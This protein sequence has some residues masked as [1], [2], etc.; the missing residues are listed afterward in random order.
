MSLVFGLLALASAL[1]VSQQMIGRSSFE[2]GMIKEFKGVIRMEPYPHLLV[3]RPGTSPRQFSSYYL[4]KRYKFG[5]NPA[6]IRRFDGRDVSLKGTLIYRENRTMI[7]VIGDSIRP[8]HDRHDGEGMPQSPPAK[9]GH[10]KLVGEIV[11]SKCYLGVMNPGEGIPHR[12]CAIRCVSGGIPPL[13]RV[14]QPRGPT[15]YFLLVAGDGGP[16]NRVQSAVR[17]RLSS[18]SAEKYSA[19]RLAHPKSGPHHLRAGF[20]HRLRDELTP[21]PGAT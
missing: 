7:E 19:R 11:D 3:A 12:A 10:Q 8:A 20:T 6:E 15:Q 14:R 18:P 21:A 17:H 13:L 9:L 2:W 5:F 4:V 16:V 1:A